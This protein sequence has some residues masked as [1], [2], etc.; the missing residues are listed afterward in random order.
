P[1]KSC[2]GSGES[3]NEA[4]TTALDDPANDLADR[5]EIKWDLRVASGIDV[6]VDRSTG[7]L[8][9]TLALT[10]T[11]YDQFGDQFYGSNTA[12]FE[13]LEGSP[14]DTDKNSPATADKS[15]VTP[16]TASCTVTISQATKSGSDLLCAW[17]GS[18]PTLAKGNLDGTC[19]GEG[20]NDLD[21]A[22]GVA[23][24]PE[25]VT[26]R[27]DVVQRAWFGSDSGVNLDCSPEKE[28]KPAGVEHKV[29]CRATTAAGLAAPGTVVDAELTGA[30]DKDGDSGATPDL[31]CVTAADGTC[32]LLTP[33]ATAGAAALPG[34]TTYRAWID[35]DNN[36]ATHEADLSEGLDDAGKEPGDDP[37]P[38]GT[39]VV[40]V[41]WQGAPTIV[42]FDPDEGG[43]SVGSCRPLT[44]L[45]TDDAGQPA[46]DVTLDVEQVHA[47]SQDWV[48]GNEPTVS[49]CEPGGGVNPAG[50]DLAQGDLGVPEESPDD[51]GTAGGRLRKPTD[52]EGLVTIGVAVSPTAK[53]DGSGA[54][55]VTAYGDADANRD[56]DEKELKG[57]TTMTWVKPEGRTINCEDPRARATGRRGTVTCTVRDR[58]GVPLAGQAV[59]FAVQGAGSLKGSASVAT[60]DAGRARARVTSL[61]PGDQVVAATLGSDLEGPEPS[62]VDD[63]DR[64]AGEPFGAAAGNCS[65]ATT[66]TWTQAT[67]YS[68]K[69]VSGR[70]RASSSERSYRAKVVD[71]NGKP[72]AGA[73]VSWA[74]KGPGKLVKPD[75][76]T[77]KKGFA[78]AGLTS[79][80][81]GRAKLSVT[82]GACDEG[83]SCR[84]RLVVRLKGKSRRAGRAL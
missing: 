83:G 80:R 44:I 19:G 73:A 18:A 57:S 51:P 25:P 39:D 12:N 65:D 13:F 69:L 75:R 54:V 34:V 43:A 59:Q 66:M 78:D 46:D 60:D 11:I 56:P 33:K 72:I 40:Q 81:G 50:V 42:E 37:E 38:D 15:C 8:G 64:V 3:L 22:S 36:D 76:F 53:S 55:T 21:D 29:A 41:N 45:V 49:F 61:A 31:S 4:Q 7:D 35:S 27:I 52:A 23:D 24:P 14:S 20:I 47:F 32:S 62:D 17:F 28:G 2:D 16:N 84:A 10:A 67:P 71:R 5:V 1:A 26:D 82:T 6:E 58:F 9:T 63:C 30:N 70:A 79:K 74:E 48:D 77:D 68:V